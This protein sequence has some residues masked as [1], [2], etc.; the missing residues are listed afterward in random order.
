MALA[1]LWESWRDPAGFEL[2]TFCILTTRP[3]A[4]VGDIHDRMPVIVVREA[5]EAWL[6]PRSST[7]VVASLL[8]PLPAEAMVAAVV[9]LRDGMA[10]NAGERQ[11]S[12]PGLRLGG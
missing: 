12:L 2:R 6:D 11:A 9:S 10:L 3:N 7:Q 1:G 4:L 8:G 5:L